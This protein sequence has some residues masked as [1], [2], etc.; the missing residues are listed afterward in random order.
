MN[1]YKLNNKELKKEMKKFSRTTFGKIIFCLSYAVPLLLLILTIVLYIVILTT[2]RCYYHTFVLVPLFATF[3]I[4]TLI[5]FILGS[6]YYYK[7]LRIY[8]ETK[9]KG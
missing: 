4:L 5:S 9:N 1:I 3:A 6:I 7:E 2:I 8:I